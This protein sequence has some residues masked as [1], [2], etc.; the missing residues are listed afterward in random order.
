MESKN[1]LFVSLDGLIGDIAWRVKRE[2]HGARYDIMEDEFSQDVCDGIVEKTDDW[3]EELD[4]ADIVIVDDA[5]GLG[6]IAEEVREKGIPAV[7][8]TEYTDSLEAERG[9]G[10]EVMEDLGLNVIESEIFDSLTEAIKRVRHKPAPYVLKP[11]GESQNFNHLLYVGQGDDGED[12]IQVMERY[13]DELVGEVDQVQLQ[14]RKEGIEM[15][16]CGFFDGNKFLEP[17]NYTFEHKR[18]F[19]G[20]LGPMTGE[21]GTSMFWDPPN[22]LFKE[23]VGRFEELLA[24]EGYVG[25]FDINC[26]VNEEAIFPLELTPRFGYPQISVQEAALEMPVGEFFWKL[27]SE[28]EEAELE[29][30]DGYQLGFR[31]VVPPFPYDDIDWFDEQSEDAVIRFRGNEIP[32]G[33]HIEDTKKVDD[34]YRVAGA[35]GEVLVITGKGDTMREAQADAY[36]TAEKVIL[37]NKYYRNDIGDHWYNEAEKLIK[38]G[39]L[40]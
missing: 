36:D 30:H 4:W 32:E 8:G 24:E 28:D 16:I 26:I 12:V 20:N 11:C 15:S 22:R 29:V 31:M 5:F 23:T 10:D 9:L 34:E 2:G 38:W 13:R 17:I 33:V 39:Y 3:R 37:P 1:F 19:P 35:T 40:R 14:R 27:A 21:M 6:E 7:G 25:S 18:L